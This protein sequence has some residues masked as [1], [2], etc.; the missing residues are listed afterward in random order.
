MTHRAASL[1]TFGGCCLLAAAL[2]AILPLASIAAE[3]EVGSR[4][5]KP[6]SNPATQPGRFP[7]GTFRPVQ[8]QPTLTVV[9]TNMANAFVL[10]G[11]TWQMKVDRLAGFIVASGQVPDLISMTESS[12]WTSCTTTPADNSGDYDMVDR[13]IWRL[14]N[15]TNVTYRVAY[16]VGS[17]GSFGNGRCRYYSGDTVI[18]NPNRIVNLTP[19]DV[20]TRAQAGYNENLIGFQ[21]RR[22]LPLCARGARTNVPELE[23]LID[24]PRQAFR[25]GQPTPTAPAWAQQVQ[26]PDGSFGVV[27]TLGRF[28][29]VGV[30]GSSFDVVTTHPTST[31]ESRQAAPIDSFIAGATNPPYRTTRPYYPTIVLGDFNILA[32]TPPPGAAAWPAGTAQVFRVPEDVMVVSLGTGAGPLPPQR[33]L[34]FAFGMP[35]PNESPCRFFVDRSFSDHCGLLVRLSE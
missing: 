18:Y 24:G 6:P 3:G 20:A 22:S 13:L 25:C 16:L 23:Q 5:V 10:Q 32:D 14:R 12:G 11:I 7:P 2:F 26:N 15:A 9:T 33:G 30:A 31:Q 34:R 4:A 35:L 17:D 19:G 21:V 28:G 8:V 29:L 1:R 27:A